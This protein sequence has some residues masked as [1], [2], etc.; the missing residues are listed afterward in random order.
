MEMDIDGWLLVVWV[1]GDG[2][3]KDDHLTISH[4]I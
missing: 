4:D 2:F 3:R 1:T